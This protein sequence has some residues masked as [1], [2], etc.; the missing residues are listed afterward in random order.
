[1]MEIYGEK[2]ASKGKCCLVYEMKRE[3]FSREK[4]LSLGIFIAV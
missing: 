4:A 2:R 3:V 1:M